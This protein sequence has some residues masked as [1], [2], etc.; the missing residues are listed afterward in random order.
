MATQTLTLTIHVAWWVRWY[1]D[2]VAVMAW[3]SNA[4]PD[5][6]KVERTVLRGLSFRAG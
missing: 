2:G 6:H 1:L 4:E 5:W 3:L